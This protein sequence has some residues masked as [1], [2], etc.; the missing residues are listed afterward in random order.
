MR[1]GDFTNL[2]K[3]GAV[4]LPNNKRLVMH[5]VHI[6]GRPCVDLRI[7]AID[8]R[9]ETA[10]KSG[11]A[12]ARERWGEVTALVAQHTQVDPPAS[13]DAGGPEVAEGASK[14]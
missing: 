2:V 11:F 4:D 13:G 14:V 12:V 5:R 6:H 3:V 8:E 10:T 9:G 7:F 1:K